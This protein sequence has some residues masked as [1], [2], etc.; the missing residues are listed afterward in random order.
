MSDV[1]TAGEEPAD[2]YV[3]KDYPFHIVLVEPEIPANTGNDTIIPKVPMN[4]C[5]FRQTPT[6]GTR[7]HKIRMIMTNANAL[8][9]S[10]LVMLIAITRDIHI[11]ASPCL[12]RTARTPPGDAPDPYTP[13]SEK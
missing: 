8:Q 13:C 10:V 11:P 4:I 9:Q 2:V 6:I 12:P 1:R 5:F 7:C 3:G